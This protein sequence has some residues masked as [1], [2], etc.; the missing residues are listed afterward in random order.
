[1]GRAI[2]T[3]PSLAFALCG[4]CATIKNIPDTV[5]PLRHMDLPGTYERA[6]CGRLGLLF[7]QKECK[8]RQDHH[9][10]RLAPYRGRSV[11]K[12]LKSSRCCALRGFLREREGKLETGR[13]AGAIHPTVA[14]IDQSR[15]CIC[16]RC[17]ATTWSIW[18]HLSTSVASG[19][20]EHF[21]G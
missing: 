19:H 21:P 18:M 11:L 12:S 10:Q 16:P 4:P 14:R 5:A 15:Y 3:H 7:C 20:D 6:I 2:G 8:W 1:V 13:D 17:R 9:H